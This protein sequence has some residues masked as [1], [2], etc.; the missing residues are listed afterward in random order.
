M[1]MDKSLQIIQDIDNTEIAKSIECSIEDL[2][3]NIFK[4]SSLNIIHQNIRS[5]YNNFSDFEITFSQFKI[6]I[7][8]IIFTECRLNSNK[9]IPLLSN[10]TV[11]FTNKLFNQN[12]GVVVYIKN[13]HK[14]KVKEMNLIHASG[15]E[16]MI[17]NSIILAIYRSPSNTNAEDFINSLLAHLNSIKS[18]H[19]IIITGDININIIAKETAQ[20][21]ERNNRQKYLTSLIMHGILPGHMFPTRDQSCLD[22]FMLKI[23]KKLTIA[24]VAV[25]N[26]SITDHLMILL[27]LSD[28]VT[29]SN[30]NQATKTIVDYE[31]ACKL[32]QEQ[33]LAELFLYTDP[34]VY[35]DLLIKKKL[36][37]PYRAH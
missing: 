9:N 19:N 1:I 21:Y 16:I 15:L 28:S 25:L 30:K 10:Y 14:V 2:Q 11:Y 31:N 3:N 6:N 7:D 18:R 5:I 32:L 33:N 22:H 13:E 12:D 23:N 4:K 17:H 8:V 27:N 35:T 37:L 34:N 26:T 36:F 29:Q 24:T 20:T